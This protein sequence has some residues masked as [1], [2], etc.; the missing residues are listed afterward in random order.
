[1]FKAPEIST[2]V[3]FLTVA[4]LAFHQIK[5]RLNITRGD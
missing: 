1:L 5:A 4:L 3:F 2:T